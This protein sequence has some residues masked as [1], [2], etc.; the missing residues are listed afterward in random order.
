MGNTSVFKCLKDAIKEDGIKRIY[1][2][3]LVSFVGVS[4]FRSTFFGLYDTFKVHT[5]NKESRWLLS[6][7]SA[8]CAILLTYPADTVRR[9]MMLTT[10]KSN[11]KLPNF[12]TYAI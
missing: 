3:A 2:G 9:R 11:H 4:L 8:F 7:F 10:S 12:K 1:R 5:K 6:Y